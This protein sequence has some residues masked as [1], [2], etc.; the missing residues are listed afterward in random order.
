V[1]RFT[2]YPAS[3]YVTPRERVVAAIDG[4]KESCAWRLDD[5]VK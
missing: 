2:I 5:F 4:I 1:P 3:H